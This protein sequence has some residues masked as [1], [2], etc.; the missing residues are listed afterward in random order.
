MGEVQAGVGARVQG[1]V[2]L[3]SE[4]AGEDSASDRMKV[5]QR[6]SGV[7]IS[8][9]TTTVVKNGPGFLRGI[10]VQGGAAGTITIYDNTAASG[11]L[12]GPGFDATNALAWYPFDREFDTGLTIV[13]SAATKIYVEYR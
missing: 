8:T 11:T 10:M 3:T 7:N 12:I 2:S 9:A 4:I 6:Y 13:T 5:E 1:E